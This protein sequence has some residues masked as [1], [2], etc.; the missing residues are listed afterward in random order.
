MFTDPD[1]AGRPGDG[2]GAGRPEQD[3]AG[4]AEVTDGLTEAA[5]ADGLKTAPAG[6]RRSV[7]AVRAG[8]PSPGAAPAAPRPA[9]RRPRAPAAP[10]RRGSWCGSR[11]AAG[12]PRSAPAVPLARRGPRRPAARPRRPRPGRVQARHVQH[13]EVDVGQLR[14]AP[15][16][17][18][19]RVLHEIREDLGA[20][21]G[22]RH[23]GRRDRARACRGRGGRD[24]AGRGCGRR[25]G[26]GLSITD[27]RS[28]PRGRRAA[29]SRARTG[30]PCSACRTMTHSGQGWARFRI[31]SQT[32][33]LHR[34]LTLVYAE[35]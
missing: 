12:R 7:L 31:S 2:R 22:Q 24:G 33:D 11:P 20:A 6:G 8:P 10:A 32:G 17:P 21:R 13:Q 9:P 30:P 27:E 16:Q 3:L 19:H 18:L 25:G 23:L 26:T 34:Q 28:P 14:P 1:A 4:T 29:A 5:R 35:W 15:L